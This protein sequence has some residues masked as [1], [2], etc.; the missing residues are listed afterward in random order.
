MSN[1]SDVDF[2]AKL[3]FLFQP[4]RYKCA[5]GGRGSG[6]S[7]GFARALLVLAAAKP[8]RVLCTR[9]TQKSIQQSVHQ[10]LS[11][12]VGAIGLGSFYEIQQSTIKGKNGSA[13]FFS[14]LADQTIE[15][16][17]SFEGVDIVWVEE[18]QTV[19]KRSWDILI[20]TI[21]KEQSEIWVSFN[22]ELETDET[23][24]RFVKK[25]PPDCVTAHVNYHDNPW[26]PAVLEAERIH[27]EETMPR[28]EYEH[29][30]GGKCLPAV[31]G[32][33]YFDEIQAAVEKGRVRTVPHDPLLKTHCIW[34]LGFN[35]SMSIIM[36]QKA[37][38]EMRVI[39]YIEDSRRTL[40]DYMSEIK[41]LD[42]GS[43]IQWGT[44]FLP[45][46]GFA[47]R[48]QTGKSDEEVLKALGCTVQ[49]V[50]DVSVE[51]GIKRAREMFP[52]IYFDAAKAERL[53]ECL[54]RY[55]RNVNRVTGE[56]GTPVHDEYSHGADSFRYLAICSELLRNEQ[57][58]GKDIKYPKL[59]IV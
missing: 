31:E 32:A 36:A 33:I 55:R 48:H 17:K 13:F 16:L 41:A 5:Y 28:A 52:Q 26:F 51:Q 12:Q 43:P 15:S 39:H 47:K 42:F 25:P 53:I 37:A 3:K 20:P 38:S 50:P 21:R 2:P 18:G 46:D 44:H 35:D 10:L 14:G 58:W 1:S 4:S 19:S 22:P 49:R 7:W 59:G 24:K 54:K 8:M 9:E 27:A 57:T 11:D 30:W 23:Y 6:K 45:H 34:D 56:P 29:T 40:A